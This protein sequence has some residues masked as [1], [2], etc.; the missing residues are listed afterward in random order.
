MLCGMCVENVPFWSSHVVNVPQNS[1]SGFV[2]SVHRVGQYL[3]NIKA[4]LVLCCPSKK[5]ELN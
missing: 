2:W 4:C 3:A 1:L 5:K